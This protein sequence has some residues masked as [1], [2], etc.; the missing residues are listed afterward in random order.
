M[1][2]NRMAAEKGLL[3][4]QGRQQRKL[5]LLQKHDIGPTG[6]DCHRMSGFRHGSGDRSRPVAAVLYCARVAKWN[7]WPRPASTLFR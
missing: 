1:P 2:E 5:S 6:L 7:H 4:T 3:W